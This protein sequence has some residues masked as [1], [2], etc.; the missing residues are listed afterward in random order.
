MPHQEQ[1]SLPPRPNSMPTSISQARSKST[2]AL[3]LGSAPFLDVDDAMLGELNDALLRDDLA[4]SPARDRE[5]SRSRE[6][7]S[8]RG[9]SAEPARSP[10]P[11]AR[12]P[13]PPAAL[14]AASEKV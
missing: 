1:H 7:S 10:P 5:R 14:G 2:T 3:S 4:T 8:L 11:A 13:T 6:G 12:S 9:P